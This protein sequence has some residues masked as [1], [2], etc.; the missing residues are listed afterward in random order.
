MEKPPVFSLDHDVSQ[1]LGYF[2]SKE[3]LPEHLQSASEAVGRIIGKGS[4]GTCFVVE[5]PKGQY[6]VSA[7][8]CFCD[9][10]GKIEKKTAI[11]PSGK[12]IRYELPKD[13]NP[14]EDILVAKLTEQ[15]PI[16]PL[17]LADTVDF[18]KVVVLGLP[19][20]YLE[21]IGCLRDSMPVASIGEISE[22]NKWSVKTNTRAEAGNSGSP[23][24][25]IIT[26]RVIG[27]VSEVEPMLHES[28]SVVHHDQERAKSHRR[29]DA[30]CKSVL[31]TSSHFI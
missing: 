20:R 16:Q 12:S 17:K 28:V 9:R 13:K 10:N 31:L 18:K 27:T 19:Y 5:G 14:K 7:R 26:G 22:K 23:L 3:S 25:D 6:L 4:F 21:Y 2:F 29:L 30:Y 24:L 11:L 15:L 8:H 1:Q